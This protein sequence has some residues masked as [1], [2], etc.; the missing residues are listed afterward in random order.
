MNS[1]LPQSITEPKEDPLLE[2]GA[3]YDAIGDATVFLY[4]L[5]PALVNSVLVPRSARGVEE[6]E[7]L[8]NGSIAVL[9]FEH[10]VDRIVGSVD[11]LFGALFAGDDADVAAHAL[12]ELHRSVTGRMPDGSIYHAWQ[13][14]TWANTWFVQVRGF[15]EAYG[16][17]RGFEDEAHRER[18][19]QG[20]VE[21][22]RR[23]K[24]QDMP[25]TVGAYEA[26]WQRL[27]SETLVA[28]DSARFL[29]G[30][31]GPSLAKPARW[32]WLPTPLWALLTLPVRRAARIGLLV[33]LPP[34][35][36]ASLGIERTRVDRVELAIHRWLWSLVPRRWSRRAGPTWFARRCRSGEGVW[37][38]RYGPAALET[39][40]RQHEGRSKVPAAPSEA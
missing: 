6:H 29:V 4:G 25:L 1:P 20:F 16:A 28:S 34:S 11:L 38:T 13:R 35:L 5:A 10:L 12:H 32:A 8:V 7:R 36:D 15:M 26:H 22:G 17:L 31:V 30:Q 2:G 21:L 23:L 3:A 33:T 27:V 18:V 9:R 37:R 19:Y 14:E 24:V 40:R 39:R